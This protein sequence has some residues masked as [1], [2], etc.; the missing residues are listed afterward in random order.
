M[1]QWEYK[2][3][4]FGGHELPSYKIVDYLNDEGKKGWELIQLV[5]QKMINDPFE[6]A[7][8]TFYFKRENNQ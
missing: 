2:Q 4:Y 1:K 6:V 3:G 7:N 8:Y 5:T